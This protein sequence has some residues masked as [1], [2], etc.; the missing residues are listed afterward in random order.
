MFKKAAQQVNA[1]LEEFSIKSVPVPIEE[2]VEK[3]GI[4]ISYAPSA[5]YSGML[6]RKSD[7]NVLM[8]INN[9]ENIQR[10]RFTIAHELGHYLLDTADH[11]TVDYRNKIYSTNKP[12]KERVADYF[13]ANILMPES[14]IRNDF[15]KQTKSGVFF[16]ENL[17]E[18][19]DR[20][21]VSKEAIKYRLMNLGLIP[22]KNI[23]NTRLPK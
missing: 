9:S 20:Y 8:G 10:M 13:A 17:S 11:V 16:E 21:Q 14:I 23:H 5:E 3:G 18:M 4:E 7:G 1:L 6:L 19:A 15:K 22:K 12:D 2:M